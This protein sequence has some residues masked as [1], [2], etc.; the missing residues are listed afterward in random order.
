MNFVD[1]Q[2]GYVFI[3]ILNFVIEKKNN[4]MLSLLSNS[5]VKIS[6]RSLMNIINSSGPKTDPCGTQV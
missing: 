3:P 2:F 1:D 6:S 4:A 5:L